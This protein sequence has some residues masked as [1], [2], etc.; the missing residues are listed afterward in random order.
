MKRKYLY[1]S[2]PF[3]LSSFG[4]TYVDA[5]FPAVN[6]ISNYGNLYAVLYIQGLPDSLALEQQEVHKEFREQL[7]RNHEEGW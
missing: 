6:S 4:K 5:G 7:T 1:A 2:A 3:W